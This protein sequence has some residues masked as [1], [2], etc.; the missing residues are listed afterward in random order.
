MKATTS[1]RMP[2]LP[3]SRNV[4]RGVGGPLML[5]AIGVL[6]L[7]DYADGYKVSQ[8]WP[9]ILILL[10]LSLAVERLVSSDR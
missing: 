1:R 4:V 10:G 2:N 7:V 9:T 6:F 5:I 3:R 8:T